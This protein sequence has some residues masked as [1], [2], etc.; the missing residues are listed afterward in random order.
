MQPLILFAL[1]VY[2]IS[3][4]RVLC[5]YLGNEANCFRVKDCGECMGADPRCSWCFDEAY[6]DTKEG[7]GYRCA[8]MVTLIERGCHASKIES[9]NSSV[10]SSS[11]P[12]PS[13]TSSGDI[14]LTPRTNSVRVR[15]NDPLVVN[16]TFQSISDYPVDLYFLTDLSYTMSDDLET[17]SKLTNDIVKTMQSVTKKLKMGFGAFVDKPVFPFVVPTPEYLRNPCLNVGT[18]GLQCDPPFLFKHILGLTDDYEKF[19][20]ETKVTRPSGN[21]DSPEGGLDALLQVARCG[22]LIGWRSNARKIVLFASDGG[23]HLAGDGRIAGLIRPP[24]TTCQVKYQADR[25]NPSLLYYGWHTADQ[26]DYPSVGEIAQVLTEKDISVIFAVDQKVNSLYTKLAEF[27]PSAA[28]GI[29][30]NS[31]TNIVRL[32]RDNYDKIANKAELMTTYDAEYLDV[33]VFTRCHNEKEFGKKTVCGDHPVGGR[34]EYQVAVKPKRCFP[35]KK[36]VNLKMVALDDQAVLEVESACS[37]PTCDQ[38]PKPSYSTQV[39]PRCQSHGYLHCGSCQC[40]D[41]YFG[42]FCECS[43]ATSAGGDEA[44]MRQCTKPGDKE[45]CSGR[46]RCICGKCKCNLARY[47]GEHCECDRHG[48]KRAS[49]DNQV[50]GGPQRGT[51]QCDGV[52]KCKP[53]YTGDRCDC[54]TSDKQCIDPNKPDGPKCSGRGVC[55]CGQCFCNSGYTGHLCNEIQG[56]QSALCT[57][58]EVEKCVLCLRD[59]LIKAFE[60]YDEDGVSEAGVGSVLV[61]KPPVT[62]VDELVYASP[63][64][65]TAAA[66]CNTACNGTVIDTARVK[67]IENSEQKDDSNLCIIYTDDNCRVFFTYRYSDAIYVTRKVDLNIMRKSECV[68]TINILYIVLGVIAGIVLGG[69]ILLLIYKLVITID[70]RR[71][72]AKF[73]QQ[74]ENMRW[75]MAENPIFESPTTKVINPT[76]EETAY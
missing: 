14:Q 27:L 16:F 73:E 56:G 57:D 28:V 75:E 50:C 55:D 68:K 42:D 34:I 30:T 13:Q 8:P 10:L 3:N 12:N 76:Y 41:E 36:L 38:M 49:D 40:M 39:S 64:Y 19:R 48:C 33:Q 67:L 65:A 23:F 47:E 66:T 35:G 20:G 58:R 25:F 32:L 54:M 74:G 21:L 5:Q 31:S 72:L 17:V 61:T 43:T 69:L 26:T 71:E 7:P 59:S 63:E 1:L 6:D 2:F 53:G 18:K 4:P 22:D 11:A 46:G 15:P 44:M 52:C 9:V 70:D 60:G 29:L 37:C 24:P 62:A 45:P 51:C